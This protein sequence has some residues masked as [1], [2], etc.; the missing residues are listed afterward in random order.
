MK[1]FYS[2]KRGSNEDRRTFYE[3]AGN[4]SSLSNLKNSYMDVIQAKF[5][6]KSIADLIRLSLQN[7]ESVD[8]L[9]LFDAIAESE[10]SLQINYNSSTRQC[11]YDFLNKTLNLNPTLVKNLTKRDMAQIIIPPIVHELTHAYDDIIKNK[12]SEK[13][14]DDLIVAKLLSEFNAHYHQALN[15]SRKITVSTPCTESKYDADIAL[16]AG[17][18]TLKDDIPPHIGNFSQMKAPTGNIVLDM[19]IRYNKLYKGEEDTLRRLFGESDR[20]ISMIDL[21][22]KIP[23]LS[24]LRSRVFPTASSTPSSASSS[25]SASPSSSSSSSSA[26]PE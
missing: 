3:T 14:G 25:S 20:Y 22:A 16:I 19:L 9:Q 4:Q 13:K 15:F 23:M 21:S 26:V 7:Y 1:E 10:Q 11:S 2:T 24:E 8:G 17:F 5:V 12:F 18:N 6:D